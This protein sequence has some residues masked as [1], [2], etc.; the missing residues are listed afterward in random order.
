MRVLILSITAGEGHNSTAKALMDYYT[1]QGVDCRVLDTYR[2]INKLLAKT[3]ADGYLTFTQKARLSYKNFYRIM[4]KRH[5]PS[6]DLSAMRMSNA[7]LTHK[8][9]KFIDAYSP[10]AVLATHPLA[11]LLLDIIKEKYGTSYITVGIN[12][13]FTFLPY[14]EESTR[15]D[16]IVTANELMYLQ[17]LKKGFSKEQFLPL[18]IPINPK[19]AQSGDKKAM[20]VK[21]G[22]DADKFTVLIMSGS[23]GYGKIEDTLAALDVVGVDFQMLVVCG[24]NQPAKDSIDKMYFNKKVV[25]FGFVPFVDELMDA[26][27]CIITKPG[28]LSTSEALAKLLPIIIVNPIPGQE[29][30]NTEFLLNNG[31]A[32]RISKTCPL[33]EIIYQYFYFS[34]KIENMKRNIQMLAKPNAT[35]NICDFVIREAQNRAKN[36]KKQ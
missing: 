13:D 25:T 23:M 21:Y 33:D 11:G 35:A 28:G 32:M 4:E 27:D 17:A 24:H 22:L 8:L 34:D 15:L 29:D 36:G 20:R 1:A 18:G 30:R 5:K 7:M 19:F 9:K 12:T 2:Y 3:F 16:Y 10:D 14:W 26:A 31:C 6:S